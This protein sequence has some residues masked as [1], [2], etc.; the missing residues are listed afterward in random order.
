MRQ[1]T[2]NYIMVP[3]FFLLMLVDSH[4]TAT[5]NTWGHDKYIW[6]THLLLIVLLFSST[7]F[8]KR[9][10]VLTTL[11]LGILFDMYYVGVIGIYTVALPLTVWLI[12]LVQNVLTQ[13]ILT[14]FFGTIIFMTIF[15]VVISLIQ[16]IFNL[17]SIQ[18]IFFI[19]H[20]LGPTLFVNIVLFFVLYYP[21][22][23]LFETK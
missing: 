11:I 10:M 20:F 2:L 6:S 15:D 4:L 5:F 18:G 8:S 1:K 17:A 7:M 12:F 3:V 16:S 13:N 14:Y 19:T 22:K 21:L 9:Y 23:K